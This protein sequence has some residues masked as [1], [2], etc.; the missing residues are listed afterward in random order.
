MAT[1]KLGVIHPRLEFVGVES[2]TTF[3]F[4]RIIMAPDM[5]ES[6]SWVQ[7]TRMIVLFPKFKLAH[8]IGDYGRV[9]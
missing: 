6:Q 4:C 8:W 3:W 1:Y 2:L 9:K 5:L 7:K